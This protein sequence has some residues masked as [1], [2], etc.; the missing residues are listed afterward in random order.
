[1]LPLRLA[2]VGFVAASSLAA[3]AAAGGRELHPDRVRAAQ[4]RAV[5]DAALSSWIECVTLPGIAVAAL[6]GG[7]RSAAASAALP[8]W[9]PLALGL[10]VVPLVL[11]AS[12]RATQAVMDFSFRPAIAYFAEP[13]ARDVAPSAGDYVAPSPEDLL[14]RRSAEGT[15]TAPAAGAVA[16]AGDFGSGSGG[17]DGGDLA[18]LLLPG[19]LDALARA[20]LEWAMDGDAGSVYP[21]ERDS[22]DEAAPRAQSGPPQAASPARGGSGEQDYAAAVARIRKRAEARREG[23]LA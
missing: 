2:C 10:G 21:L 23:G 15:G 4:R 6:M 13:A 3:G 22:Q 9:L 12:A 19:D 8:A 14:L 11:P 7:L 20:R 18:A 1:M 5:A 17:G 16:G